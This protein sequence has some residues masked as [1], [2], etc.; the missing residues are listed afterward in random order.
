[1]RPNSRRRSGTDMAEAFDWRGYSRDKGVARWRVWRAM[2]HA[3]A[4]VRVPTD[5]PHVTSP[6]SLDRL[7]T[8]PAMR[9]VIVAVIDDLADGKGENS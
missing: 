5:Q 3:T 7:A 9:D 6:R 2:Q 1:M 4:G 8:D